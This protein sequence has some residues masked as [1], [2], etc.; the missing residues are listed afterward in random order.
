MEG[1]EG[2][3]GSVE[4]KGVLAFRKMV[5]CKRFSFREN[6]DDNGDTRFL[7]VC[8]PGVHEEEAAGRNGCLEKIKTFFPLL[9]TLVCTFFWR[10]RQMSGFFFPLQWTDGD[11]KAH[12]ERCQHRQ[13]GADHS[14][15]KKT[16]TK[17]TPEDSVK[18]REGNIH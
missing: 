3:S 7:C 14:K 12:P 18:E 13:C 17:K 11:S 5:T 2:K 9:A 1:R 15:N 6:G 10:R 4:R 8:V 16:K